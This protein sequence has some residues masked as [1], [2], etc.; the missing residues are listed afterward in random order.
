[1]TLLE[2]KRFSETFMRNNPEKLISL[3]SNIE[4]S[5]KKLM[6]ALYIAEQFWLSENISEQ[7]AFERALK[8]YILK[9]KE[10]YAN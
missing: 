9:D 5:D 8:F 6:E 7:V 4:F 3:G 10:N 1:M 2:A